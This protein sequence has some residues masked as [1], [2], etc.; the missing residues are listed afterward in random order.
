MT[1]K[2]SKY[3][4]TTW[5]L[6]CDLNL[7]KPLG[8]EVSLKIE[9]FGLQ[10]N[11]YRKIMPTLKMMRFCSYLREDKFSYPDLVK[12]SNFPPPGPNM[13][14][15]KSMFYSVRNAGLSLRRQNFPIPYNVKKIKTNIHFLISHFPDSSET[16]GKVSYYMIND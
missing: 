7:L 6:N 2:V 8:D 12:A 13:C 1:L 5:G 9:M 4:R 14:P 11:E 15:F 3:N 16:I 10:G